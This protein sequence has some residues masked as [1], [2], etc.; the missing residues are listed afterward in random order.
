MDADVI[1]VG[2]GLAG[3]G[4]GRRAGRRRPQGHP[5][6]PGAGAV[7]RRTG[8]L[9][10]RRAVL[11]RQP[12]AAPAADPRLATSSRC[13]TGWAR[14]ASTATRTTGRASGPRR[15]STSPPARSGPGCTSRACGLFPVVGWAERGGYLATGHGNSVPR[16]HVTW[17]TGPGVVEPFVRRVREAS[18]RGLVDAALPPPGQRLTV[19]D[20]V[21]DGVRGECS[22]R[23]PSSA[24]R[25]ARAR[26]SATS[27]S[28]RRR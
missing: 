25:P 13:R 23:A 20:G 4:R 11:R 3:P 12:R 28:G 6:R 24:G 17:G 22:S 8:V 5:G 9:V 1:V 7:A 10:V 19:T 21:V 2:G 14:P 18:K 26:S 16:F 27:S 15:T